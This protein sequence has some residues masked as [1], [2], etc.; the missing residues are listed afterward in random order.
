MV[1]QEFNTGFRPDVTLCHIVYSRREGIPDDTLIRSHEVMSRTTEATVR[2]GYQCCIHACSATRRRDWLLYHQD[3]TEKVQEMSQ[4]KALIVFMSVANTSYKY[5]IAFS[6]GESECFG[7]VQAVPADHKTNILLKR[8]SFCEQEWSRKMHETHA[9]ALRIQ[10]LWSQEY[11]FAL[12]ETRGSR[13]RERE[14]EGLV[15][16]LA[17]LWASTRELQVA[18]EAE[19]KTYSLEFLCCS[20]KETAGVETIFGSGMIAMAVQ[21]RYLKLLAQRQGAAITKSRG[22]T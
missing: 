7:L 19:L 5:L 16:A 15:A 6:T 12:Q 20:L 1:A 17:N 18:L 2:M 13:E 11:Y 14:I 10:D 9:G 4:G 8:W 21:I 22:S 3:C